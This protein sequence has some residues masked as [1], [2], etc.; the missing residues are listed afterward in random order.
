MMTFRTKPGN[1]GIERT[2][3]QVICTRWTS[4]TSMGNEEDKVKNPGS[5]LSRL[6]D[7]GTINQNGPSEGET[8]L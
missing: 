6:G 1:M 5:W 4:L 7:G 8:S 2:W 3:I